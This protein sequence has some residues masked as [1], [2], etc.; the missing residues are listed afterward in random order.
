[1]RVT[2]FLPTVTLVVY[3]SKTE[4]AY[5]CKGSRSSS[6]QGSAA[7]SQHRP[8]CPALPSLFAPLLAQARRRPSPLTSGKEPLAYTISSDVFP[9]PP[10]PTITTFTSFLPDGAAAL[11]RE[12]PAAPSGTAP[13]AAS[14]DGCG[15]ALGAGQGS[16]PPGCGSPSGAFGRPG[17]G[18]RRPRP[19]GDW[20]RRGRRRLRCLRAPPGGSLPPYPGG[21]P[22]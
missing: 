17:A 11:P 7:Q 3:F 12:S 5:C 10:S 4:G 13:L 15:A 18:R 19:A 8:L 9:Q 6:R 1:M 21:A 22:R 2:S 20:P 16:A 14:M